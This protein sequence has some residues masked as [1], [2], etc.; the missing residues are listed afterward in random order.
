VV[1]NWRIVGVHP[2]KSWVKKDDPNW[3]RPLSLLAN[4]QYSWVSWGSSLP[5][6]FG[7]FISIFLSNRVG[8][9]PPPNYDSCKL[10]LSY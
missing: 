3:L 5:E 9:T 1:R 10:D 8:E 2:T 6:N 7:F 4:N